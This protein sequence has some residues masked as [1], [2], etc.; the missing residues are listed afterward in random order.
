MLFRSV[1]ANEIYTNILSNLDSH[2][3]N[4]AF[5]SFTDSRISSRLQF[6]LAQRKFNELVAIV[7]PSITSPP[8]KDLIKL[9]EEYKGK[10][11]Q[12]MNDKTI[13]TNVES[14]KTLLK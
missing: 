2:Q 13:K 11:S 5:L 14:L 4:I 8:V 6:P 12:L 1:S 10:P 3:A 9:V 7:K